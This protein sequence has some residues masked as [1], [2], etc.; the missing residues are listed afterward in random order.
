[1]MEVDDNRLFYK[2]GEVADILGENPS[3][4]RFWAENFSKFIKPS[5]T[6]NKNNRQFSPSDVRILQK[7]HFLVKEQG[8]TLEGAKRRLENDNGELDGKLAVITRL[9][10]LRN[11]LKEIHDLL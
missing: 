9:R 10:A 4:V 8:M 1:M 5:R 6:A 3:L 2:I 11:E 7:I